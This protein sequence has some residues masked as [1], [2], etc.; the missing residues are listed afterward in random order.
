MSEVDLSRAAALRKI[1]A[2]GIESVLLPAGFER[3]S[4]RSWCRRTPELQ[5]VIALLSRRGRFDVQWGV[6]SPEAVPVLWG[7][8]FRDGDVGA[9]LMSGTPGTIHHPPECQSFRLD[10][11]TSADD[12]EQV[13]SGVAADLGRV[14]ARLRAFSSR[15]EVRSYLLLNRDPTD[16]RDFVIP[17]NLP[18]KLFSAATLAVIDS[19]PAA[20]EL[21]SEAEDAM[22]P[23]KDDLSVARLQRLRAAGSSQ[24]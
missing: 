22:A 8:D 16:R 2:D 20:A 9:A 11:A 4:N 19:D 15:K 24:S 12:A 3:T 21:I 7:T 23:F 6:V 5:H 14:E 10:A 17:A 18:L 13:A 1:E